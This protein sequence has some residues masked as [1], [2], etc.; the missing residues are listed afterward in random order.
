MKQALVMALLL[1]AS[2][3]SAASA[4][5]DGVAAW[6]MKDYSQ[7]RMAWTRALA[8]GGPAEAYNNLGFLVYH[9]LGGAQDRARAVALWR[10]GAV[11]SVSESQKWLAGAYGDGQGGLKQSKVQAWAWL[12]CAQATAR[13]TPDDETEQS[14]AAE[15]ARAQNA[16]EPTMS[17]VERAE[18]EQLARGLIM[19]YSRPLPP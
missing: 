2:A 14:I 13:A 11:L 6:K 7:A 10:I 1:M 9:G 16:I 4:Y 8:E 18:A 17:A 12:A 5:N 3:G 19:K 15:A